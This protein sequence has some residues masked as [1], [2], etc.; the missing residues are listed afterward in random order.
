[1]TYSLYDYLFFFAIYSFLG[2][3]CEVCFCSID[4][5]KFVNRGFLNGP[6]CPIYGFGMVII[7]FCLTPLQ[8]NIFILFAG[9]FIL[10]TLLE[11]VA[12]WALK[13]IF[14]TSW[15]DYSDM[16]FNIGGYVC[17]KFSILWGFAACFVVR[18]IHPLIYGIMGIFSQ[19]IGN[20]ILWVIFI[21][22]AVDTIVTVFTVANLNHD[23]G[24]LRELAQR[25]RD[26]SEKMAEKLG[27]SAIGIDAKRNLSKLD[28]QARL[29][30][31]KAELLDKKAFGRRRLLKA[32]PN[33]KHDGFDDMIKELHEKYSK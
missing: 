22:L 21:T 8:E 25:L 2:W 19:S 26:S 23:L 11:G 31:A 10:T 15:W 24:E 9:A 20:I 33:M 12:G 27:N 18:L 5:G 1:M 3:C 16:P 13:V 17:L 28:N 4:T 30:I 29:D 32:F 6:V 7:L 14:H